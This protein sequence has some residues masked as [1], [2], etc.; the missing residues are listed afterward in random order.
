MCETIPRAYEMVKAPE[1]YNAI[2]GNILVVGPV[3]SGK[4]HVL[5]AAASD[6][7]EEFQTQEEEPG[8]KRRRRRRVVTIMDCALLKQDR[9]FRILRDALFVAFGDD[10]QNIQLL[11]T[12][13]NEEDLVH[14]C[15]GTEDHLLW[16]LDQWECVKGCGDTTRLQS[17]LFRLCCHHSMSE[18]LECW[19]K[20]KFVASIT[21]CDKAVDVLDDKELQYLLDMTGRLPGFLS[22]WCDALKE[23]VQYMSGG[24]FSFDDG[25]A[26]L[27]AQA[28]V[29]K[30]RDD[31]ESMFECAIVMGKLSKLIDGVC[32]YLFGAPMNK[33]LKD[34]D[35][36]YF[37]VVDGRGALSCGL[38]GYELARLVHKHKESN[39]FFEVPCIKAI[40]MEF[41]AKV[42]KHPVLGGLLVERAIIGLIAD[43]RS[44]VLAVGKMTKLCPTVIQ[45]QEGVDH[46]VVEDLHKEFIK[47]GK[48][49]ALFMFLT[50][51]AAYKAVD[52]VL[53]KF[54]REAKGCHLY[55]AGLQVTIGKLPKHRLCRKIFMTRKCL[56]WVPTALNVEE[57]VSWCMNWITPEVEIAN[58]PGKF[59]KDLGVYQMQSRCSI[60]KGNEVDC[61]E[62]FTTF[63]QLDTR[64][65]FLDAVRFNL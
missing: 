15:E 44:L 21:D 31:M 59:T 11:S 17:L 55:I 6:F 25:M 33:P 5:A 57:D 18:E 61:L 12:C 13:S 20:W 45:L 48:E 29:E 26:I 38:V 39:R 41:G 4:S 9:A 51:S 43:G 52:T 64:L 54:Q 23:T 36:R 58:Y 16:L 40:K 24:K 63:R 32:K 50:L 28:A 56:K 34:I 37:H 2:I 27:Q 14:F 49:E 22:A 42:V 35:S 30:M 53:L 62:V 7:T 65:G 10:D 8:Q 19:G 60:C 47:D 3:G 1:E 46:S